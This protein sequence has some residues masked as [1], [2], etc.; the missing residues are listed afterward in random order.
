MSGGVNTHT[1]YLPFYFQEAKGTTTVRSGLLMLPY[2]LS[3]TATELAVGF[4]VAFVGYFAPFISTGTALF[5]T[6]AGILCTLSTHSTTA[7]VIGYQILAAIGF[8]ASLCLCATSV[9]ASVTDK[10]L[11]IANSLTIFGPFFGGALAASISQNIFRSE[12]RRKLISSV[13]M[14]ETAMVISTGSSGTVRLIPDSI[15]PEVFEAFSV[16]VNKTFILAAVVGGL[17]FVS[18]LGIKWRSVKAKQD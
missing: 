1:F 18:S 14:N 10:D 8:G 7:R 17:A 9:R 6:A 4:A 12:L 16:A 2:L 15:K 13:G 5:T 3:V 11:P